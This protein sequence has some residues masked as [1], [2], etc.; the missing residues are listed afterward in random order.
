MVIRQLVFGMCL[1]YLEHCGY[2]EMQIV[3]FLNMQNHPHV[4]NICKQTLAHILLGC[5]FSYVDT[6]CHFLQFLYLYI[7]NFFSMQ[8]LH[9]PIFQEVLNTSHDPKNTSANI[10]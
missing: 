9:P 1:T 5:P 2:M 4:L 10:L 3:K 6:L 7:V 8:N